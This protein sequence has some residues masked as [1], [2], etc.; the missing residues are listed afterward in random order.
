MKSWRREVG[1]CLRHLDDRCLLDDSWLSD[2][3]VVRKRAERIYPDRYRR[4]GLALRDILKEACDRARVEFAG[5]RPA[6]VLDWILCGGCL[7]KLAEQSHMDRS[8]VHRE[9]WQPVLDYLVA[10]LWELGGRRDEA[11]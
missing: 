3:R 5:G 1:R 6:E 11:A 2:L 9:Y 4:D 8:Q 7:S 10:Y